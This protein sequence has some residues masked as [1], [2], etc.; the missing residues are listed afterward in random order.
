[1]AV[2]IR[3]FVDAPCPTCGAPH[4]IVNGAWLRW[5]RRA[6]GLTLRGMAKRMCFSAPY[7][8][9]VERNRRNCTP[10]IRAAYEALSV[11]AKAGAK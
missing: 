9:D 2:V 6:A 1:M 11:T 3:K 7:L 8:C 4:P 5:Q 10:E